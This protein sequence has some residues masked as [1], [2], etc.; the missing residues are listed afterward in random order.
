MYG[1][2]EKLKEFLSALRAESLGLV[3]SPFPLLLLAARSVYY[4]NRN[5]DELPDDLIEKVNEEATFC[6]K[7]PSLVL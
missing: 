5:T 6:F 2:L 1:Y 4:A 7:S 3:N